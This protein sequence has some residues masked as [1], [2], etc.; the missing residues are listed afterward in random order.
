MVR[1]SPSGAGSVDS[2]LARGPKLPH[3]SWPQNQN[4][5]QKQRYNKFS[6]DFKNGPL[7]KKTCF[8][9]NKKNKLLSIL[10]FFFKPDFRFYQPARL[11]ISSMPS[12]RQPRA[13]LERRRWFCSFCSIIYAST[14]TC[15]QGTKTSILACTADSWRH[16]YL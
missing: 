2:T 11:C 16:F 13:L 5:K 3:A 1:T 15:S 9:F 8:F 10:F 14:I 12:P 6:K 7:P 4:V